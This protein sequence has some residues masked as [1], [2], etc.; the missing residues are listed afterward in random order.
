M[1][2]RNAHISAACVVLTALFVLLLLPESHQLVLGAT[3]SPQPNWRTDPVWYDGKAEWALYDAQRTIYGKPRYYKAT[4][5]TNKQRMDPATTTKAANWRDANTIEVFK[6]NVSEMIE[7]D[8]YTYRFLTTCFVDT[9]TLEPYKVVASSQEDCGTTYKQFVIDNGQVHATS[10]SYFSNEGTHDTSYRR[11]G[12]SRH[13][14]FHDTLTLTLR[15][16]PFDADDPPTMKLKLIAD[17]TNNH[18]T[19]QRPEEAT[20]RLVGR[21][22]ITVP[23]GTIDAH[24]LVV[25]HAEQGGT[26]RS[27]YWFAADDAMRHVLV[28]YEGPYGVK[29]ELKRLDW[30][31]YWADPRPQE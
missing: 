31:A 21:K 22:S 9:K 1:P 26:T 3:Q 18:A 28:K 12:Q 14:A 8:N 10:N 5:F 15:D 4:I 16:Y 29:Y 6:H 27:D 11:P 19:P 23:Y 13:F 17:Q 30:W 20:V 25:E 2:K 24:H 7:T